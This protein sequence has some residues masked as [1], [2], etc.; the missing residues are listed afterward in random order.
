MT[1]MTKR[2]L[3]DRRYDRTAPR[4]NRWVM[5]PDPE[6]RRLRYKFLRA[7]VQARYWL[8]PWTLT[9]EEYLDI[10]QPHKGEH[11]RDYTAM[12]LARVDRSQGWHRDNV[13]VMSRRD[14]VNRPKRRTASGDIVSRQKRCEWLRQ[15]R[16]EVVSLNTSMDSI[17]ED[18]LASLGLDLQDPHSRHDAAR[19]WQ[20]A[21]VADGR[22]VYID[23]DEAN[24][25]V[26]IFR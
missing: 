3:P 21:G 25:Q 1:K 5:G 9:W 13:I 26:R 18:I 15:H 14:I 11:G 22:S 16:P 6:L 4:P 23:C 12:N 7:R 24:R 20:I 19:G 8:Q 10:M 17:P 2:G